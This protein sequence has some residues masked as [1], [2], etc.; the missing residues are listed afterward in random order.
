MFL[1]LPL[2]G[3][4]SACVV[5]AVQSTLYVLNDSLNSVINNLRVNLTTITKCTSKNII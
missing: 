2:R 5:S 3:R 4:H 1:L